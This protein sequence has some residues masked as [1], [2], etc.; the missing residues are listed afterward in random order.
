[1]SLSLAYEARV[2][3]MNDILSTSTKLKLLAIPVLNESII[4]PR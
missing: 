3:Y 2:Y 4:I 1:M